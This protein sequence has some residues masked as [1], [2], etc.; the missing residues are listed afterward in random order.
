[1]SPRARH[2]SI[3]T[4]LAVLA[5][6]AT[7][8][9]GR[10]GEARVEV[11][12]FRTDSPSRVPV[13]AVTASGLARGRPVAFLVHGFHCNKSMMVPIAR[14]LAEH[15]IDAFAVD[16][17]GHGAS[18]EPFSDARARDAAREALATILAERGVSPERAIV[19]GHSYGASVLARIAGEGAYR[20]SVLLGPR[21]EGGI[22]PTSPDVLVLTANG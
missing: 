20:A 17:P 11:R 3:L 12:A 2:F 16:L 5:V 8:A 6:A 15:G 21:Y 19:I 9:H 14:F 1:M 7:Y 22:S 13:I 10:T 4:L 18:L